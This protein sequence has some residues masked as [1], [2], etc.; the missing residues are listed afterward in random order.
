MYAVVDTFEPKASTT[1]TEVQKAVKTQESDPS[2]NG[3]SGGDLPF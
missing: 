2:Q 1:P 3:D